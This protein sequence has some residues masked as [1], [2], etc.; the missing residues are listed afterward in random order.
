MA[1]KFTHSTTTAKMNYKVIYI[2]IFVLLGS[3]SKDTDHTELAK[4]ML[5]GK[6]WYLDYTIQN[7][8][9]KSFVGRSTYYIQFKEDGTTIDADGITGS[10]QIINNNNQLD[11]LVNGITQNGIS[12][13]YTYQINK[14]GYETLIISYT[15]NSVLIHK[16]FTITH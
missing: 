3:C 12:A 7:N 15:Q 8:Q 5:S 16:I 9:T 1:I 10:F 11:L 14:I 6:T 4:K 13:N 2:F